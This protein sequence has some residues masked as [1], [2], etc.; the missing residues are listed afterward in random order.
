MLENIR[1]IIQENDLAVLATSLEDKPHCSLMAYISNQEECSLIH[2]LTLKT[3][4]KFYNISRNPNVSL[5]I[6]TRSQEKPRELFQALTISGTCAPAAQQKQPGLIR[7]LVKEH[8]QLQAMAEK[9]EAIAVE[10]A[11]S[12]F[13]LLD[14]VYQASYYTMPGS[15]DQSG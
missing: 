7:T 1:K 4:Q 8:P 15:H 3:T 2:M 14:G 5:L 6:D 9:E 12:S 13:L 10:V 11:V